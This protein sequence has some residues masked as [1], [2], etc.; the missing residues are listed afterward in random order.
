MEPNRSASSVRRHAGSAH[1]REGSTLS[2]FILSPCHLVTLSLPIVGLGC[3]GALLIACYGAVLVRDQQF[4]YRDAAHFYYPL[5]LRVQQEWAAG[6]VPL[7]EP[8]E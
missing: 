4:A 6:R 1:G 5:Y 3:V 7:W 2:R 8:E